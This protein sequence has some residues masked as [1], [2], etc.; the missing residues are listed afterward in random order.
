MTR[1]LLAAGLVMA[2][3]ALNSAL[4]VHEAMAKEAPWCAVISTGAGQVE[5]DCQYRSVED[6]RPNVIAGNRGTCNQ[7]PRYLGEI[8]PFRAHHRRKKRHTG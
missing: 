2:A 3:L 5:W 4:A 7:N 6:C 8:A 1:I